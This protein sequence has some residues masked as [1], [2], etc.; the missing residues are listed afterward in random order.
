MSKKRKHFTTKNNHN[1]K[2]PVTRLAV[3]EGECNGKFKI[4]TD[5]CSQSDTIAFDKIFREWFDHPDTRRWC[6]E[7]FIMYFKMKHPHRM[8]VT[9]SQYEEITKG[10]VIH[11]T[12][13]EWEAE[14]N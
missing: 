3:I 1:A 8:C 12:K 11:A 2:P 10:R 13:E 9:Y 14:N 5:F 4:V 6:I 7:S